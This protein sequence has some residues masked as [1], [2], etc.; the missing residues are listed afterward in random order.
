MVLMMK[1][2]GDE[3]SDIEESSDSESQLNI[4]NNHLSFEKSPKLDQPYQVT[5]QESH[6]VPITTHIQ[7]I[8]PKNPLVLVKE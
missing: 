2:D 4:T 1:E 8:G 6:P 7:T 3:L 5:K